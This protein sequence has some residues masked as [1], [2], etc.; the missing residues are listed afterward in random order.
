M[1]DV[2]FRFPSKFSSRPA[3][4]VVM[5]SSLS[6][7]LLILVLGLRRKADELRRNAKKETE[8]SDKAEEM[9]TE[10]NKLMKEASEIVEGPDLAT[11][12]VRF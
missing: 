1:K 8:E 11:F 10:A 7:N 5:Y 6:L 12:V 9:R 4:P 3:S 2:W